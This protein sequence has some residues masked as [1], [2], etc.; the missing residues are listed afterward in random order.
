MASSRAFEMLCIV[1]LGLGQMCMFTGYDTQSF[2]AES[3]L[4]SVNGREPERIDVFAGY[5][6]QATCYATYL[7]TC[8]F[9]PSI[10][11]ILSPKWTLFFGSCGFTV[12]QIGFLYLNNVYYYASC[13][14]MGVGFALYYTGHGSYL[15]SHST[16][17]T[18][19]QNAAISWTIACLC[20]VM[21]SGILAVIFSLNTSPIMPLV[22]TLSNV[23]EP[24]SPHKA[25][26]RQFSDLEIRMMYGAFAAITFCANLIFAFTPSREIDGCIEGKQTRDKGEFREEM[27]QIRQIFIDKRLIILS[28]L[29]LHLGL[30][31]AFWISVYP[32]SLIF[33]KSLSTHIYLPALYSLGV[34][35][36]EVASES[37]FDVEAGFLGMRVG[38]IISTMSK[39]I[40]DFGL[41]PTMFIGFGLTTF[42]MLL[43]V[44]SVP[45]WAT[46]Q[47]TDE[48]A[49]IIQPSMML[50]T[51]IA[52]LIGMADSCANN[53]RN[54]ICTLALPDKRA[55][56]FAISKFYQ[57]LASAIL[58][59]TSPYLSIQHYTVIIISIVSLSTV[60]F[61]HIAGKMRKNEAQTSKIFPFDDSSTEK[62]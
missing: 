10:L 57:A 44:A 28:P 9:A 50:S 6:G 8:L 47:L 20:M 26:Y 2:I 13:A 42:A 12:Y 34:G 31:T 43:I 1:L 35:L 39:R 62:F 56:T 30:F 23:T 58:M 53:V 32:T 59:F 52:F 46:V 60:C 48:P 3:V 36:G 61:V 17:K 21:G 27:R 54:V 41:E 14:I 49:W 40:K 29:F 11:R 45:T 15:T 25:A 33:T 18:L 22:E 4:H 55:Q 16:R 51:A 19:E 38:V 37:A 24:S 5:Y 7:I